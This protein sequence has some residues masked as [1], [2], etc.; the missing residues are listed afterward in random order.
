MM[1]TEESQRHPHAKSPCIA[2]TVT[3]VPRIA[4]LYQREQRQPL[5]CQLWRGASS[6]SHTFSSGLNLPAPLG[7]KQSKRKLPPD[8]LGTGRMHMQQRSASEEARVSSDKY[9]HLSSSADSADTNLD[10]G[11][12]S[13]KRKHTQRASN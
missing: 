1:W 3:R 12:P 5:S 13:D 7:F 8:R 4:H 6:S 11:L 2:M 9:V 10:L